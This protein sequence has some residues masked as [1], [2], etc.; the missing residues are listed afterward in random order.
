MTVHNR[1]VPLFPE[2]L[3]KSGIRLARFS[4]SAFWEESGREQTNK[5]HHWY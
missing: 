3:Q 2:E 4:G 5:N 1:G